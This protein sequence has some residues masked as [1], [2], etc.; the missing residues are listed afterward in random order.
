MSP[1]APGMPRWL[2]NLL[3]SSLI[4]CA[5]PHAGR[6]RYRG[7][8]THASR[9]THCCN[10]MMCRVPREMT[11]DPRD[12]A[13]GLGISG[14]STNRKFEIQNSKSTSRFDQFANELLHLA[15]QGIAPSERLGEKL[16]SDDKPAAP[17]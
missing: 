12:S 6:N 9:S 2:P 10:P 5:A 1:C 4:T 13:R 16:K 3:I 14:I 8:T 15:E 17:G 11:N 7:L